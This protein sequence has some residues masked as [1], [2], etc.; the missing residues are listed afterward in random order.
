MVIMEELKNGDYAIVI[1]S[2]SGMSH[3]DKGKLVKY[4]SNRP[5]GIIANDFSSYEYYFEWVK[6][7]K[8]DT[9]G[10]KNNYGRCGKNMI[11]KAKLDEI[12]IEFR[13][14]LQTIEIW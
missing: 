8:Y 2:G 1:D 9:Y 5:N 13:N 12:P 14:I 7:V 11:R 6:D 4:L 3:E 10:S